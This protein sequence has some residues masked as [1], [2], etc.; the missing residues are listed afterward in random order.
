MSISML[1]RVEA[2]ADNKKPNQMGDDDEISDN[3][4]SDINYC[5]K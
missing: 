4:A 2:A 1:H 3:G 5:R